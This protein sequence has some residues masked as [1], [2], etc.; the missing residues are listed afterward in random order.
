MK[1]VDGPLV[2]MLFIRQSFCSNLFFRSTA[3][4][5][6]HHLSKASLGYQIHTNR[7]LGMMLRRE[8]PLAFFCDVEGAFPEAVLRYLRMFDRHVKLGTLVKREHREPFEF[9]GERRVA[10]TVFYSLPKETWRIDAMLELRSHIRATKTWTAEH[11]RK[12][13]ALLGYTSAQN[14]IWIASHSHFG[15]GR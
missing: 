2:P 15:R 3:T 8:K 13:G 7:E 5:I 14:D 11:E 6:P 9:R 10:L 1:P 4:A 12:E